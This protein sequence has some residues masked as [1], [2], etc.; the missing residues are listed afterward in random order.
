MFVILDDVAS[1]F[2]LFITLGVSLKIIGGKTMI[3]Y[4]IFFFYLEV[5]EKFIFFKYIY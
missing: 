1:L 4:T 2:E 3:W 5:P